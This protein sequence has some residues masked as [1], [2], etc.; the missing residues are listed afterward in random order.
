[1]CVDVRMPNLSIVL[2]GPGCYFRAR[3][4]QRDRIRSQWMGTYHNS[5]T[6]QSVGLHQ[7]QVTAAAVTGFDF[8][9]PALS[10]RLQGIYFLVNISC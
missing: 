5:H 3:I 8:T 2:L 4:G 10:P 6:V 9:S 7:R 1:M